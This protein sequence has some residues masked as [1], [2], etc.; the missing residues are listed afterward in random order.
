MTCIFAYPPTGEHAD[1][2]AEGGYMLEDDIQTLMLIRHGVAEAHVRLRQGVTVEEGVTGGVGVGVGEVGVGTVA[3]SDGSRGSEHTLSGGLFILKDTERSDEL[4]A[5]YRHAIS[6]FTHIPAVRKVAFFLRNN[7]MVRGAEEG[8]TVPLDLPLVSFASN[9]VENAVENSVGS[10]GGS[11]AYLLP[12]TLG[13]L[14]Q[15]STLMMVIVKSLYVFSLA[16]WG[17]MIGHITKLAIAGLALSHIYPV[18]ITM[19]CTLI[20]TMTFI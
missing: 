14:L 16:G 1:E 18:L 20:L 15:V 5:Q 13:S 7:I 6:R 2:E 12:I 3:N 11:D 4:M 9:G 17:M 19:P 8:S 10:S